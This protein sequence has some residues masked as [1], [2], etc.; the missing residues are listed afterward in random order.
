MEL[1]KQLH[2]FTDDQ[3]QLL[4]DLHNNNESRRPLG[5][6]IADVINEKIKDGEFFER[7]GLEKSAKITLGELT[8]W[9][10]DDLQA[11]SLAK[12]K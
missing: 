12:I 6:C 1:L 5:S 4:D 2:Q 7:T 8:I 10:F 9:L 11:N 3:K